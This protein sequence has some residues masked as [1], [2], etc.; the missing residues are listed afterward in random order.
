[1][2]RR[3]KYVVGNFRMLLSFSAG[4]GNVYKVSNFI[5]HISFLTRRNLKNDIRLPLNTIFMN[6]LLNVSALVPELHGND[7]AREK[8]NI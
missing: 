2:E 7:N 8:A 1:M 6:F 5:T 4:R 3:K